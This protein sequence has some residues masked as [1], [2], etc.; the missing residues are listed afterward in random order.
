MLAEILKILEDLER[1]DDHQKVAW[2]QSGQVS[3]LS[4]ERHCDS[5]CGVSASY[6][7]QRNPSNVL[8]EFMDGFNPC[9]PSID[10]TEEQW[11]ALAWLSMAD[12]SIWELEGRTTGNVGGVVQ[13]DG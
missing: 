6:Q 7:A 12:G 9:L 13:G 10:G 5:V 1:T 3:L 8:D 2:L 11:W 4:R